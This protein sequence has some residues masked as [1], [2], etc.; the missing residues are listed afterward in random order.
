MQRARQ[1]GSPLGQWQGCSLVNDSQV[2]KSQI[3]RPLVSSQALRSSGNWIPPR[4]QGG[5][6]SEDTGSLSLPHP[7]QGPLGP[8]DPCSRG[9]AAGPED[10]VG[11]KRGRDKWWWL[12]SIRL[13][14]HLAMPHWFSCTGTLN[15]GLLPGFG[16]NTCRAWSSRWVIF[17]PI[18][19]T[20]G[21]L[22][23]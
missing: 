1:V 3:C 18:P 16:I 19:L 20:T 4:K 17:S 23:N 10:A 14:V 15:Q 12:G 22:K 5:K 6:E 13:P 21:D 9:K 11:R 8:Q 2:P 7:W